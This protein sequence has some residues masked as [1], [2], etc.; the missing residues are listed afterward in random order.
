MVTSPH[1]Q[2][3]YLEFPSGDPG[4]QSFSMVTRYRQ[5][6]LFTF[7]GSGKDSRGSEMFFVMPGCPPEQL[8]AFGSN[9]WETPFGRV[10]DVRE[11]LRLTRPVFVVRVS[12]FRR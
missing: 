10:A 9:S 12:H 1:V 11:H 5:G 3:T 8:N 4:A 7:A 6:V 2:V